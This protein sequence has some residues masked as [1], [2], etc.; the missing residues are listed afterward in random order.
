MGQ[1][2]IYSMK[3][4][5]KG[6]VIFN[7]KENVKNLNGNFYAKLTANQLQELNKL[8]QKSDFFN[9]KDSYRSFK[10]DLPTKFVS[11]TKDGTVKKVKAYDDYPEDLDALIKYADAFRK[12]LK[13][14]AMK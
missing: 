9:L 12:E 4:D 3:I 11:V 1:C 5:S 10:M 13:W 8:I 2:P 14:M 7:G 6:N